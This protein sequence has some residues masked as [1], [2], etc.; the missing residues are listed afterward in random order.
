[1][2]VAKLGK[3][4]VKNVVR[5]R[6]TLLFSS[7]GVIVGI[8][9]FLFF[10][11]LGYG[12][13]RLLRVKV[14]PTLPPN[15]IEVVPEVFATGQRAE[16]FLGEADLRKI[17]E[18][19]KVTA[20][21]QRLDCTFPATAYLEEQEARRYFKKLVPSMDLFVDGVRSE[22]V[23][24]DRDFFG[25]REKFTFHGDDPAKPIPVIIANSLYNLYIMSVAPSLKLPVFSRDLFI[26]FR[27]NIRLGQ[28][29]TRGRARQG[30]IRERYGEIVGFSNYGNRAGVTIPSEY[31]EL[32]NGIYDGPAAVHRY[33][34]LIVQTSSPEDKVEVTGKLRELKF[35]PD[36]DHQAE[37]V[38][39]I[40]TTITL[41]LSI[42]SFVIVIISAIH[43]MH[44]FFM[45][46]YE[47]RTEIGLMRSLGATQA[48]IRV[49][50]VG[51]A[52][53]LGL[54]SG[55]IG[56][57]AG[58]L[59]TRVGDYAVVSL[60]PSFSQF[61]GDSFFAFPPLI[62]LGAIGFAAVFCALGALLPARAAA[63]LDPAH[64]LTGH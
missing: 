39:Q 14:F 42:I 26:G 17:Q 21:H 22:L 9:T 33:K 45:L 3:L 62:V 56:V 6:R 25:K 47:R 51:E 43:I 10:L 32:Y 24:A 59:F 34:S 19:P 54:L 4:M 40:V 16:A 52:F 60:A 2:R 53:F 5:S 13:E 15:E 41:I 57:V 23:R 30:E 29:I 37:M 36:V 20:V 61:R 12:L 44:T 8:A 58:Y 11:S 18:I 48:D 35:R 49:L 46:I 64:A 31:L 27:F 38:V 7:I 55:G 28:G 1:M 63:R 50:I